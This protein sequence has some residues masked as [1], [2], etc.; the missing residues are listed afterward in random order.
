MFQYHL[1]TEPTIIDP[2]LLHIASPV[3]RVC[4]RWPKYE[5]TEFTLMI[6]TNLGDR[7]WDSAVNVTFRY[8]LECCGSN[9]NGGETDFFFFKP[10]LRGRKPDWA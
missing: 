4:R 1:L 9:T 2:I 5:N 6:W 7:S 8:G 3:L 10:L